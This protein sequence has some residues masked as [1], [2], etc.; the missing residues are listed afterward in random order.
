MIVG[1]ENFSV[2]IDANLL[3]LWIAGQVS[4]TIV[5]SFRRT[6]Q[7]S[8][9]DYRLLAAYLSKFTRVIVTPNIATETSNLLGSLYGDHL[10]K[11]RYILAKALEVWDEIY[12][13]SIEASK[14]HDY[15]RLGLTDAGIILS[16]TKKI[17]ILTDDFDLYLSLLQ[18][19]LNVTNFTHIRTAGM[20]DE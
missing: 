18:K 13:Q 17:E 11:S 10:K 1:N 2:L 4:E 8:I 12:I 7:Y 9:K 15:A 5:P 16:A 14:V 3:T 20:L 19:G 6:R